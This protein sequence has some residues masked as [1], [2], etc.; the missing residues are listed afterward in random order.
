MCVSI[1][2]TSKAQGQQL[3]TFLALPGRPSLEAPD[4]HERKPPCMLPVFPSGS[5]SLLEKGSPETPGSGAFSDSQ[6]FPTTPP[7]MQPLLYPCLGICALVPPHAPP[8]PAS[9]LP[10]PSCVQS[11]LVDF[12]D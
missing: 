12:L 2:V 8:P 10:V 5:S 4:A 1:S 3:P 9:L 6:H 11:N 7:R